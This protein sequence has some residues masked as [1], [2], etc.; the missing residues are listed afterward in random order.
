MTLGNP[1]DGERGRGP[2]SPLPRRLHPIVGRAG[3]AALDNDSGEILVHSPTVCA[4][5]WNRPD[6]T[7]AAFTDAVQDGILQ[8]AHRMATSHYAAGGATS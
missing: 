6:A 1:Y 4:G 8:S 3:K 7:A 5:Y 2:S